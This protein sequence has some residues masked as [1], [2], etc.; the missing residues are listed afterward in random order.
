MSG[1]VVW[2]LLS[3]AAGSLPV[4]SAESNP[5]SSLTGFEASGTFSG[6]ISD[7]GVTDDDDGTASVVGVVVVAVVVVSCILGRRECWW[8]DK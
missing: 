8:N 3:A 2:S 6:V 5:N 4:S 7:G 1:R